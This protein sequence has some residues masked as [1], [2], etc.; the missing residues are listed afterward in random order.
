MLLQSAFFH[1]IYD[2]AVF[3]LL[4]QKASPVETGE[5]DHAQGGRG[6]FIGVCYAVTS[7]WWRKSCSICSSERPFVSGT[8][9]KTKARPSSPTAANI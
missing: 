6:A 7:P 3:V 9:L 5:G 2:R 1:N 4:Q 8:N